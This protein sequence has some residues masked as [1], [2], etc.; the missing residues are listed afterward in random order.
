MIEGPR[1]FSIVEKYIDFC[2]STDENCFSESEVRTADF[3]VYHCASIGSSSLKQLDNKLL[4]KNAQ[5]MLGYVPIF[6]CKIQTK[7]KDKMQ[8]SRYSKYCKYSPFL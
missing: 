1:S 5:F 2:F 4:G 7:Y 8:E 6:I 3:L